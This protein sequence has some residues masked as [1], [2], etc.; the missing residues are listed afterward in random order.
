MKKTK[1]AVKKKESQD[2]MPEDSCC[3]NGKGCGKGKGSGCGGCFYFLGFI[4][5]AFYYI[6]TATSFGMGVVGV[7]KSLVWP[8][9]LVFE[10]MKFLGM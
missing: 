7:L 2:T 5:S 1:K 4:G 3:K 9:F 8:A 10:L 6:S